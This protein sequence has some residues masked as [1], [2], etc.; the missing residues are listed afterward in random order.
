MIGPAGGHGQK[1]ILLPTLTYVLRE[2]AEVVVGHHPD[3]HKVSGEMLHVGASKRVEA[4]EMLSR[5]AFVV[6]VDDLPHVVCRI[7]GEA[8]AALVAAV[9]GIGVD[10]SLR[11]ERKFGHEHEEELLV[12]LVQVVAGRGPV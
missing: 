1:G 10:Q 6:A 2:R 12:K 3:V 8:V 7:A 11:G 4:R 9:L 5:Q